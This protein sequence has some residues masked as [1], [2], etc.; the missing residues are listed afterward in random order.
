[1]DTAM[2]AWLMQLGVNPDLAE[3]GANGLGLVFLITV[4]ATSYWI[5]RHI[6]IRALLRVVAR[7]PT[8]W[9]DVLEERKVLRYLAYLVPAAVLYFLIPIVFADEHQLSKLLTNAVLIYAI[10]VGLG[11]FSS[12]LNALLVVYR[13]LDASKE[14]P[15]GGFIQVLKIAGFA[16]AAILIVAILIDRTA[17]YVLGGLGALS[18]ILMLVFRDALLG[19]AAGIQLSTNHMI[20]RGD[21]IEMPKYDADGQVLEVGLTTVK[22]QNADKSITT[23]PTYSLISESFK[24][25][26]G[27]QDAG[28]RRIKR[29]IYLDINSIRF[30]DEE[31]LEQLSRIQLISNYLERETRKVVEPN[32]ELGGVGATVVDGRRL[33]NVGIYRAYLERYLRAHPKINHEMAIVVRQLAPTAQGLPL[34]LYAYCTETEWHAYEAIQAEIFDH[35]L[36]IAPEFDLRPF[37]QPAGEDIRLLAQQPTD[38]WRDREAAGWRSRQ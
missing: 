3:T 2:Q 35:V 30:C 7:T 5:T 6:I 28:V 17:L 27:M 31:M 21:W 13:S 18:A 24:N 33:T 19:F 11:V 16:L 25:W 20:A 36:A 26:R 10:I 14:F 9:D 15:I 32:V 12:L 23:V 34:E 1:M 8:T 38:G 29:A 4:A 37:Q 22:V